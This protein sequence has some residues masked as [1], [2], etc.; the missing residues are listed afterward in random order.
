MVKSLLNYFLDQKSY[1]P[2]LLL[3]RFAF[4]IETR[5]TC[6]EPQGTM[7]RVQ[8]TF[9]CAHIFNERETSGCE[10][11]TTRYSPHIREF[12]AV[13]DSEFLALD[14]GFPGA[15]FQSLSL[16]LGFWITIFSE[17]PDPGVVFLIPKPGIQDSKSKRFPDSGIR[18]PLHGATL[19]SGY[20]AVC[21]HWNVVM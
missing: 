17:I 9:L 8:T 10:A 16:E 2:S 1:N 7:G 18:I 3:R 4:L 14:S 15:G 11:V 5:V 13:L 12:K 6:D 20:T 19:W 21:M